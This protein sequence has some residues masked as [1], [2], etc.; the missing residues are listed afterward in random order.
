MKRE[1]LDVARKIKRQFENDP[2]ITAVVWNESREF[3]LGE[4]VLESLMEVK[5][6]YDFAILVFNPD[7]KV[8]SRGVTQ[9]ATRDNV[10][11]ELGLFIK[12][13]RNVK[14]RIALQ[15]DIDER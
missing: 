14:K 12:E 1:K 3:Q 13:V 6:H 10:L 8:E 9:E 5:G 15:T 4:S 7:D 11:F 2:D